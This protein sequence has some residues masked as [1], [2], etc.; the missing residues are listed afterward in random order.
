[1]AKI[2][3]ERDFEEAEEM[4]NPK[5]AQSSLFDFVKDDSNN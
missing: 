5:K 3:Y 4:K 2:I 1:M